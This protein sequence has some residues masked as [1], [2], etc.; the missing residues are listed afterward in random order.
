[1]HSVDEVLKLHASEFNVD[2]PKY[3]EII[4]RKSNSDREPQTGGHSD[5]YTVLTEWDF[6]PYYACI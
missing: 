5:H 3:T 1:M 6:D 4:L 2:R